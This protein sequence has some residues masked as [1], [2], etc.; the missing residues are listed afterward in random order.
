[1]STPTGPPPKIPELRP[2][3]CPYCEKPMPGIGC[4]AWKIGPYTILANHCIHCFV[5]LHFQVFLTPEQQP[6]GEEPPGGQIWKP[7]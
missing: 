1:M 3:N 2:P 5:A 6:A 4:Y 7:S